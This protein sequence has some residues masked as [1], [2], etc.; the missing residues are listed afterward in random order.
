[1][2]KFS[3]Y[4]ES[5]QKTI[6]NEL[7]DIKKLN[8][9]LNKIESENYENIIN[10]LISNNII[11]KSSDLYK[12][13][14][15]S[16]DLSSLSSSQE[17]EI[18]DIISKINTGEYYIQLEE[19]KVK[20]DFEFMVVNKLYRLLL[21]ESES[22]LYQIAFAEANKK[23]EIK[24]TKNSLF[25][26]Q[27]GK[28]QLF[29]KIKNIIENE[30]PKWK[31][32]VFTFKPETKDEIGMTILFTPTINFISIFKDNLNIYLMSNKVSSEIDN[33]I[34]FLKSELKKFDKKTIIFIKNYLSNKLNELKNPD[35]N[36]YYQIIFENKAISPTNKII[37]KPYH[38]KKIY[39][40]E[41]IKKLIIQK[42][43]RG[44][45]YR[46]AIKALMGNKVIIEQK[47]SYTY[48]SLS[49]RALQTKLGKSFFSS[50]KK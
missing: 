23:S 15:S 32:T 8:I 13:E 17:K 48:F 2:K 29:N 40:A 38:Y 16:A 9:K 10:I 12:S 7:F 19:A 33:G 3:D 42:S 14:F 46:E 1:M 18:K 36:E 5:I 20:F 34:N 44:R 37:S 35:I 4:L 11:T 30:I 45:I 26:I 21:F 31:T 39:D 47:G 27:G 22:N 43:V 49:S 28:D 24:W 25:S 6:Q 50:I 41:E